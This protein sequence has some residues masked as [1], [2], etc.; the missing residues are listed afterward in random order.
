MKKVIVI[1]MTAASLACSCS[2]RVIEKI[3]TETVTE[4]R[5]RIV[6]DTTTFEI[7]RIVE[8]IVTR[9]TVSRLENKYAK[10]DAVVSDGFLSHSLESKPQVIK[11]PYQVHVTDTVYKEKASETVTETKYVEKRLNIWQRFRLWAFPFILI[12]LAWAYRK[13]IASL[14]KCLIKVL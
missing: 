4:Y 1:I 12:L 10:S 8:K 11:V 7:E 14:V 9:D 2:P 6:H 5:D 13:Q 3:K